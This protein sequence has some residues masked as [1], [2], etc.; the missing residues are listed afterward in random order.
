MQ[1][2]ARVDPWYRSGNEHSDTWVFASTGNRRYTLT[3]G[4]NR[5]SP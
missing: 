1:V 4:E 2:E 5:A 3:E